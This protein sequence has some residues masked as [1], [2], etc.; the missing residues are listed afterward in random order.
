MS[1]WFSLHPPPLPKQPMIAEETQNLQ[2]IHHPKGHLKLYGILTTCLQ[3]AALCSISFKV[4][5][6]KQTK[7]RKAQIFFSHEHSK[8][9]IHKWL[10]VICSFLANKLFLLW[11]NYQNGY[12]SG[13]SIDFSHQFQSLLRSFGPFYADIL[14]KQDKRL[15]L[16]FLIL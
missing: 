14:Q 10:T 1:W 15:C 8:G 11:L 3:H 7:S 16:S 4:I 6:T 12:S 9:G 2:P 13:H 5:Y